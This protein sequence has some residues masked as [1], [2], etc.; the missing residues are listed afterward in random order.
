MATP[1]W[2]ETALAMRALSSGLEGPPRAASM[3]SWSGEFSASKDKQ[4]RRQAASVLIV[5]QYTATAR[6]RDYEQGLMRIT[7]YSCQDI[8][9]VQSRPCVYRGWVDR[10]PILPPAPGRPVSCMLIKK[11]TRSGSTRRGSYAPNTL[12]SRRDHN[13]TARPACGETS[14][15]LQPLS[16]SRDRYLPSRCRR[17]ERAACRAARR[18]RILA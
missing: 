2:P 1:C 6:C 14:R 3:A 11:Q 17:K 15:P 7:I 12:V 9:A 5:C 10:V 4:V 16:C 8:R 13:G 18:I